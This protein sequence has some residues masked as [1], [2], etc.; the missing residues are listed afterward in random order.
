MKIDKK[1]KFPS[2]RGSTCGSWT[3]GSRSKYL[4]ISVFL[5]FRWCWMHEIFKKQRN[6]TDTSHEN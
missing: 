2:F 5:D 6:L 3:H 1:D 4:E